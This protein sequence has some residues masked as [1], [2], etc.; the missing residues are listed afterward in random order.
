MKKL[1]LSLSLL[2]VTIANAQLVVDNTTQTPAQ[3][4]QNVLL[5]SG[6][7]VSNVTFNGSASNAAMVRDQV[8]HFLNGSATNIGLNNGIILSTGKATVAIG[9]NDS[10]SKTN[11]TLFPMGSDADLSAISSGTIN[12]KAVIEFDFVPIGN[13][14]SFNFVF[15]SEEYLEYVGSSFNDVFGF[16]ISGPGISGPFTNNAKNIALIP[17]TT[18]PISINN[19]NSTSNATYYINNGTG[20]TPTLNSSIQYDGFTTLLTASS[21]VLCGETYHIKLAISNVSDSA[22]DSAVFLQAGS[23]SSS[24]CSPIELI[25]FIDSNSNGIKD[26][27]EVN[28]ANGNF[29][30]QKNAGVSNYINSPTGTY[31]LYD[32]NL[33]NV[34]N[35][36]YQVSPEFS[37]YFSSGTT[38]YSGISI[39]PSGTQTLYFP[40]TQTIPFEDISVSIIPIEQPRPGFNY[41]NAIEL[42]NTGVTTFS[43]TLDF[44]KSPQVT[45]TNVSE[46]TTTPTPT[47]FSHSFLNLLPGE[48][49]IIYVTM[50]VPSIPAVNLGDILS[51]SAT[52]TVPTSDVIST[53]NT[54]S[55]SQIVIGAY[56][57]ND[58]ME[59]HGDKIQFNQF[60]SNDY[61]FYTIRFQNEGTAD[62][63]N[64]RIEDVLNSKI[65][66]TSV[67][68]IS[69]S[70]VYDMQRTANNLIWNFNDIYLQPMSVDEE[71]SKGYVTFKAKLKPGF[72]VGD[73]IPNTANIFFD[74]NPAIVTNTFN[75]EFVTTLGNLAFE[76]GSFMMVPNP[77]SDFVQIYLQNNSESIKSIII[78]DVLGKTIKMIDEVN[79]NQTK[80]NTSEFSKGI[81]MI[82]II[83][84]YGLKTVKKLIIK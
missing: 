21:E 83:N 31:S 9:P 76:S 5:G 36:S 1:L 6:I 60:G 70:H 53:N 29:V 25:S 45:I 55:N 19:V 69:A 81:Y 39:S 3:L 30:Y 33:S 61:L 38:S 8:G 48:A 67:Q 66:E 56:D 57:P 52:T 50:S 47:G 17:T 82:E 24:S 12:T 63:I 84:N 37:S 80:V 32:A 20:T 62:A 41:T 42:K 75:T 2:L 51:N 10:G 35:F 73:I 79:S 77:A 7:S 14:V 27:S 68:M 44:V 74:T 23:F 58:K 16:F 65:D 54:F 4:V 78:H 72:A 71:M 18:T 22:F 59:S 46:T 11:T 34:Y 43:G 13:N 40:I 49:R 15:A 28:F 26:S 64:I